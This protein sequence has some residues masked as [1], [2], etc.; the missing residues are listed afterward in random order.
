MAVTLPEPVLLEIARPDERVVAC[1]ERDANP[2][3]HLVEAM[4][5]LA[6]RNDVKTLAMFNNRM[7]DYSD[8]GLTFHGAYGYRLRLTQGVD[9]I[10]VAIQA[11]R[12]N[13]GS[14]QVALQIWDARLDL[15]S[16]SKDIPCN[17]FVF[18][19]VRNT[20]AGGN[21][22]DLSVANRSNDV[23]WGAYGANA[24]Q[25]A[26]LQEYIAAHLGWGIG[27]WSSIILAAASSSGRA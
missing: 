10:A 23:I 1:P 12:K 25:F 14:R 17:D 27:R 15:G 21:V 4:W 6:G 5:I 2:F 13:P 26:F 19:R 11:L 7:R 24:V 20:L 8:N 3:F 18:L 22:L 16:Q 9:Q